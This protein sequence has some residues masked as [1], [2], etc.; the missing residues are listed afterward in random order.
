MN[1]KVNWFVLPVKIFE[2]SHNF[3][4]VLFDTHLPIMV[5][6]KWNDIAVFWD[7]G[8]KY[9]NGCITSSKNYE[10]S[11]I[12]TVIYLDSCWKIDELLNRVIPAWGKIKM[13][14]TSIWAYWYIAHFEDSEWNIIWLHQIK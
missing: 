10:P 8:N 5:D 1:N 6:G 4:N 12:W 2:R 13:P 3:Y 7:I 9:M 14:K 11:N